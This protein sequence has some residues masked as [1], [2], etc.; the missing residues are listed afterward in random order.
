MREKIHSFFNSDTIEQA[1]DRLRFNGNNAISRDTIMQLQRLL[2]SHNPYIRDWK[3]NLEHN[4]R[5][6]LKL[7]IKGD[8]TPAG[9]HQ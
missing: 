4:D 2:Q 1:E 6:D 5:K 9:Q 3:F 8:R 7:I